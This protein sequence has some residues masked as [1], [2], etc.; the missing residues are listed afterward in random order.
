MPAQSFFLYL[1]VMA[2]STYLIR[3][4]PFA[5]VRGRIRSRFLRSFLTYIPYAV[6]TVMT[7]P[8]VLYAP[9][10]IG[11]AAAGLAV[12]ILLSLKDK[13]L[14]TVAIAASAVVAIVEWMFF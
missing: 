14:L 1:A 2:G 8:A 12:A 3:S 7:I 10:H 6:L 13:G 5:A 11:A 4:I 9:D